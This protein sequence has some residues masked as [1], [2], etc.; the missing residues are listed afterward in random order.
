MGAIKPSGALAS[1]DRPTFKEMYYRL[2]RTLI[3]RQL[4]LGQSAVLDC[5]VTDAVASD[6]SEHA[7]EFDA[8]LYIIEC[9]CSDD[10]IHRSRVEGRQRHIPG[11]H[12]IDWKHVQRMRT[13]FPPL[14]N[15]QLNVDAVR[16]L[17]EN[18]RSV[19]RYVAN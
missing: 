10:K 19:L 11:W 9:M 2:L 18:L 15:E 16:P 4:M 13:E 17:E 3:T 7:N 12:E 8:R 6:W 5:L 14:R 1:L